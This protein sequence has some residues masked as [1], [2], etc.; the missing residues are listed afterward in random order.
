MN[1]LASM[2]FLSVEALWRLGRDNALELM[3][4]P[5]SAAPPAAP[6]VRW[7]EEAGQFEL[8]LRNKG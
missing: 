1:R 5:G 4:W 7:S 2:G 8:E 6:A 3:G